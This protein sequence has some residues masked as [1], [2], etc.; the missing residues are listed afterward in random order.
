MSDLTLKLLDLIKQEKTVNEIAE[1]LNLSNKQ[2]YNLITTIRNK[3][4]DFARKYYSNGNI[5]YKPKTNI[6]PFNNSVNLFTT[7]E[8]QTI[9]IL[10]ISDLHIGNQL[11]RIDLLNKIYDYCIQEG[12]HI[13]INGGDLIDG[14]V[15]TLNAPIKIYDNVM[16]QIEYLMKI[17][18]F[19]KNI[20]NFTLLGNH[21]YS[22]LQHAGQ[23]LSIIL[24]SYRHDII[25][26][27]YEFGKINIKN[28]SIHVKHPIEQNLYK[29]KNTPENNC[30]ILKGH[31]HKMKVSTNESNCS[32]SIPSLS[33]I[34]YS[35]NN[36]LPTLLKL[37]ISFKNG[38]FKTVVINQLLILDKIY[39]LNETVSYLNTENDEDE[40]IKYEET[41][42]KKLVK[43]E[44]KY[45][46]NMSQIERFNARY[47]L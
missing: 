22:A 45:T 6:F 20:L 19:D 8:E 41:P 2:I 25:P 9:T 7:P 38:R 29:I 28:S 32:V 39:T 27:G 12:I 14:A 10:A 44:E 34:N 17:Y 42:V 11:E 43:K 15:N 16:E 30:I 24:Q 31:S 40:E 37:D 35:D 3:G 23:D 13:I 18:P 1:I 5:I 36:I 4:F 47:K 33:D 26:I 46:P 21:D